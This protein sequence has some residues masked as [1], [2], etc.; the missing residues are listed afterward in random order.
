MCSIVDMAKF[1]VLGNSLV[2][3]LTIDGVDI[4]CVP[5]MNLEAS[6]RY[7]V[8]HRRNYC[9]TTVYILVGP[10]RYTKLT[11]RREC[12]FFTNVSTVTQLFGPFFGE[13]AFL[14]IRPVVCPF[15]PVNFR[16]YNKAWCARP[17]MTAFYDQWNGQIKG[18]IVVENRKVFQFNNTHNLITPCI[19]RRLFHRHKG[20]YVFKERFTND[21]LHPTQQISSEWEKELVRVMAVQKEKS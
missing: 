11:N 17:I 14:G 7:I 1:A 10:V 12:V 5:G 8:E 19:H 2:R 21:G 9:N 6:V 16:R 18:H 3:G 15:Y 4:K 13:L 20:R